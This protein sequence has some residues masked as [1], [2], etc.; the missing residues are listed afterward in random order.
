[1]KLAVFGATGRTGRELRQQALDRGHAVTNHC[2]Q[3][4]SHHPNPCAAAR[5]NR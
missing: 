2:L 1:M 4:R 5:T 3:S